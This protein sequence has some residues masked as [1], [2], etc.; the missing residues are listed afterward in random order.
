M[1]SLISIIS[2]F[3]IENHLFM[4][5]YSYFLILRAIK[6]LCLSA[7]QFSN[8]WVLVTKGLRSLGFRV[9]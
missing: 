6:V 4:W 8:L 5:V 3:F 1:G 9:L 2:H 7:M